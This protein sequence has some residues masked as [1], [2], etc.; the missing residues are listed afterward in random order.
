MH[1]SNIILISNAKC[2]LKF[3]LIPTHIHLHIPPQ[4]ACCR[5]IKCTVFAVLWIRIHFFRIWIPNFFFFGFGYGFGSLF[6][7]Q[8]FQNSVSNCFHMCSGTCMSEKKNFPIE[9]H[10]F[11]SLSS[12][13]SAIVHKMFHST[14]VSELFFWIRIQPT[15]SD[16]FGF[17]STTLS[18][19]FRFDLAF[20]LSDPHP[21]S[22]YASLQ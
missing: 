12:V 11:F 2:S 9:K 20:F 17:R 18:I 1:K 3:W 8:F 5:H 10:N 13:W 14:T 4:L 22:S 16:S 7:P 15:L 21:W 19:W 6:W